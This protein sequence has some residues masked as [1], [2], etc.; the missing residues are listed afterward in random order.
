MSEEKKP[1]P[2]EVE[3]TYKA[4]TNTGDSAPSGDPKP[5]M[6]EKMKKPKV[7]DFK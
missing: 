3:P 4:P 1:Q 7:S 6:N 2:V 5:D